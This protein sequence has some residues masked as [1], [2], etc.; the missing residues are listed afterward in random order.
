MDF[1][2]QM[3]PFFDEKERDALYEYMNSGG[4]VTEFKK[5][6]EFEQMIAKYTGAEFCLSFHISAI[7]SAHT[8]S[9]LPS[10]SAALLS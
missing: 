8:L 9:L 1:I 4:W 2:N 6:R 10:S 3:E 5:T 7:L